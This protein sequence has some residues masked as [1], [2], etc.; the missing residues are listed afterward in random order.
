MKTFTITFTEGLIFL[1]SYLV[2]CKPKQVQ[3][4]G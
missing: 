4:L 1:Q 3:L 2:C